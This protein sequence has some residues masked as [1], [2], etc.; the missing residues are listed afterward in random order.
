MPPFRPTPG[1]PEGDRPPLIGGWPPLR[2]LLEEGLDVQKPEHAP[3]TSS[4]TFPPALNLSP[5][6]LTTS[7]VLSLSP[8]AASFVMPK[9]PIEPDLPWERV[10][11]A[12]WK[13]RMGKTMP[14]DVM[15]V[16]LE[17]LQQLLEP[18]SEEEQ[19]SAALQE[20]PRPA[21]MEGAV[22]PARKLD[23]KDPIQQHISARL[24]GLAKPA[25]RLE[26]ED[27]LELDQWRPTHD[28]TGDVMRFLTEMRKQSS[29]LESIEKKETN[30]EN[31]I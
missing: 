5:P 4:T 12:D 19:T 21:I 17:P 8:E 18:N 16:L 26:T 31:M 1:P 9:T 22:R 29:R 6:D 14:T 27:P 23:A 2:G 13:D 20:N 11:P 10:L 30:M 3:P 7:H 25:S 15:R 28:T 24:D